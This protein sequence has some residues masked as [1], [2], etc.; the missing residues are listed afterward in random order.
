MES[1][2][3]CVHNNTHNRKQPPARTYI[4]THLQ[5]LFPVEHDRLG[6]D[7]PVL[8]VDLVAA[9]HDGDVL[10]YSHQVAVPVRH[11]LV[12][13]PRCDVKHQDGALAL[14]SQ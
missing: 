9:E 7:F 3:C 10:A 13:G 5:V 2:N 12:G 8:D 14:L 1:P 4:E 6:L 11:V